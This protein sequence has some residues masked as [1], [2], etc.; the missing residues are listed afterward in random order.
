MNES[1]RRGPTSAAAS[2][3]SDTSRRSFLKLAAAAAALGPL[4]LASSLRSEE[5]PSEQP[6]PT[7]FQ[8]AC[9]T[10]PYSQFPLQRALTGIKSAGYEYV[11]WGTSHQEGGGKDRTPVIAADAPGKTAAELGR[12]CRDLGLEPVLMFSGIYPEHKDAPTVLANRIR[13]AGAAGV[14]QV[15]TFGHTQGGNRE[16]WIERFRK[17]APIAADNNVTLVVKQHGGTTGT[18]EACAE[19]TREVDH[20]NIMVNYDAGNV[21]DYLNLD[22]IPDIQKCAAEVRSFCI[23]D[24]RNWPKDQDCGP[25]LGEIDHYRLL[26]P[27][28]FTGRAMPLACENI[29]APLSARP[30]EPEGVDQLARR[31][32]LF[33]ETVIA[34]LQA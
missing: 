11:A 34:G 15:L 20:P 3:S 2:S 25:G 14:P 31:A 4:S 23:K 5:T 19:I 1:P 27:V 26:H 10:L 30:T 21:M 6:Q 17:L 24:H 29:F 32:R 7:Q 16:L 22:P 33:L 12:R 8:I 28:A 13:Q 18:G 9:M